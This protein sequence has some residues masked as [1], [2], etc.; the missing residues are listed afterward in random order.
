MVET[1]NAYWRTKHQNLEQREEFSRL[2]ITRILLFNSQCCTPNFGEAREFRIHPHCKDILYVQ[3]WYLC[4]ILWISTLFYLWITQPSPPA[5]L[6]NL[7]LHY[8]CS[9]SLT[10]FPGDRQVGSLT[11]QVS[12]ASK[13]AHWL[14]RPWF[15]RQGPWTR[16]RE[17]TRRKLSTNNSLITMVLTVN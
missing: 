16:I 13:S 7:V 5:N 8:S 1:P 17:E 2:R 9:D 6:C 15:D 14:S 10:T 4:G 12:E 3:P 11:A